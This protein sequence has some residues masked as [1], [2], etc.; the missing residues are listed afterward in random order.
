MSIETPVETISRQNRMLEGLCSE[1]ALMDWICSMEGNP[2]ESDADDFGNICVL[3][4]DPETGKRVM[5]IRKWDEIA[6]PLQPE[7]FLWKGLAWINDRH[8]VWGVD[9]GVEGDGTG[10]L[11]S[12]DQMRSRIH[13]LFGSMKGGDVK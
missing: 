10:W 7:V 13:Q 12:E 11:S 5:A 8:G 1:H 4:K 3:M 6:D 2:L 9:C